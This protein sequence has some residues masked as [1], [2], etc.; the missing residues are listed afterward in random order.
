M[1]DSHIWREIDGSVI[2]RVLGWCERQLA[3]A[4]T[5]SAVAAQLRTLRAQWHAATPASRFQAAGWGAIGGTAMHVAVQSLSRPV[6]LYWLLV[7]GLVATFGASAV[8]LSRWK[9]G[10]RE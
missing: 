4:S 8:M 3:T 1:H 7:P 2:G 10:A 9:G 6:G 5:T